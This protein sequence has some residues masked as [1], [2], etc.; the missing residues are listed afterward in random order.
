MGMKALLGFATNWQDRF[1]VKGKVQDI[2]TET[3]RHTGH[4]A[5]VASCI[6][7]EPDGPQFDPAHWSGS[8]VRGVRS[9]Q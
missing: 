6:D 8:G 4:F 5:R 9:L 7:I 2:H 1:V 3:D